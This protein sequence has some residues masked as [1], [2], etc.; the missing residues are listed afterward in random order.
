MYLGWSRNEREMA[1]KRDIVVNTAVKLQE[2]Y[3]DSGRLRQQI[4]QRPRSGILRWNTLAYIST[5]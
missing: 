3:I 4:I 1:E 5:C 2:G